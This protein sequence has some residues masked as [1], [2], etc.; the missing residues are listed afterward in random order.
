MLVN[1]VKVLK[2]DA[3]SSSASLKAKNTHHCYRNWRAIWYHTVLPA[4]RQSLH[5][6]QLCDLCSLV[7]FSSSSVALTFS[8][9]SLSASFLYCI[10]SLSVSFVYSI[11]SLSAS[12]LYSI[13]SLSVSFVYSIM[14][15]SASFLYSMMSLSASFVYSIM[16]HVVSDV[17]IGGVSRRCDF[18]R[19]SA[20][21][22]STQKLP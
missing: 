7:T 12:F 10:M 19:D 5:F 21:S 8:I 13:M 3:E 17:C 9:M 18:D 20:S 1:L 22:L 4:T 11:M 6:C 15:L 16:Q 14:S 2:W